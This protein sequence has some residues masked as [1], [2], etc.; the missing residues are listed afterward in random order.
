[1]PEVAHGDR[2]N[3]AHSL[4]NDTDHLRMPESRHQ[5]QRF[6]SRAFITI[7]CVILDEGYEL[8]QHTANITGRAIGCDSIH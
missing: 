1:M 5:T 4:A 8:L 2:L 6:I 3:L 7:P